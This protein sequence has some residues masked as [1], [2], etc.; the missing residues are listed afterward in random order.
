MSKQSIAQFAR[1][2]KSRAGIHAAPIKEEELTV[3]LAYFTDQIQGSVAARMLGFHTRQ[4]FHSRAV[5][6]LKLAIVRGYLTLGRTSKS[7]SE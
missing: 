7:L 6:V 1:Y 4:A 5:V 2:T 3:Y